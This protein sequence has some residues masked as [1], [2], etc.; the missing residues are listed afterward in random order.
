[1]P[2]YFLLTYPHRFGTD[3]VALVDAILSRA[4]QPVRGVPKRQ[5]LTLAEAIGNRE[6][7]KMRFGR[8][9]TT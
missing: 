2:I 6:P 7:G 5:A 1:M 9:E 3:I 8:Y 4:S